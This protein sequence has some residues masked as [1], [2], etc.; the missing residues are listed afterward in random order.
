MP[1]SA[2]HDPQVWPHLEALGHQA[3]PELTAVIALPEDNSLC[4]TN[5]K[6]H[7]RQGVAQHSDICLLLKLR[8]TDEI[9]GLICAEYNK[10]HMM[11]LQMH[12]SQ[13]E[14]QGVGQ[15]VKWNVVLK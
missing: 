1:W 11:S 7:L 4:S 9:G 10:K 15:S 14:M 8:H 3:V 5:Y 6:R 2:M 12:I 13:N